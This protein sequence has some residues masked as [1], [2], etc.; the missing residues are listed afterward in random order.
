MKRYI[1]GFA[2]LVFSGCAGLTDTTASI[3]ADV[4]KGLPLVVKILQQPKDST[5]LK[6]LADIGRLVLHGTPEGITAKTILSNIRRNGRVGIIDAEA[7]ITAN[8]A[9]KNP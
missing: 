7:E 4:C 5:A 9:T 6:Q 1:V 8:V 2:I 3:Q